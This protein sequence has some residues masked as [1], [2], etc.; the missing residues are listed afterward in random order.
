MSLLPK[1]LAIYLVHADKTIH[2]VRTDSNGTP[3]YLPF[4]KHLKIPIV[5]SQS[6]KFIQQT[7]YD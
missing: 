6:T 2:L 3:H 1:N 4:K 7:L 5:Y